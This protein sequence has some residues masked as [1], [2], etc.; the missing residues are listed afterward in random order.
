MDIEPDLTYSLSDAII[1]SIE[2][3]L[4][5][6]I[7]QKFNYS[8]VPVRK[9]NKQLLAIIEIKRIL[10]GNVVAW[11]VLYNNPNGQS[12]V[13]KFKQFQQEE[14]DVVLYLRNC[15]ATILNVNNI[16]VTVLT[17][18]YRNIEIQQAR[19]LSSFELSNASEKLPVVSTSDINLERNK[20]KESIE[21]YPQ[22]PKVNIESDNSDTDVIYIMKGYIWKILLPMFQDVSYENSN[23]SADSIPNPN[24]QGKQGPEEIDRKKKNF[25]SKKDQCDSCNYDFVSLYRSF[26][27]NSSQNHGEVVGSS[28]LEEM[29]LLRYLIYKTRNERESSSLEVQHF[30]ST[31]KD[32]KSLST[33]KTSIEIQKGDK[34]KEMRAKL[35]G[36]LQ[37]FTSIYKPLIFLVTPAIKETYEQAGEEQTHRELAKE[38]ELKVS[39]TSLIQDMIGDTD[40]INLSFP[41]VIED[42]LLTLLLANIPASIFDVQKLQRTEMCTFY[43]KRVIELLFSLNNSYK[44]RECFLFKLTKQY[45]SNRRNKV[46]SSSHFYYKVL[47]F[48]LLDADLSA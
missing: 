24:H 17:N 37:D 44:S 43:A 5:P 1:I 29:F 8:G 3:L 30:N 47:D 11:L 9:R 28:S 23:P 4:T 39:S 7:I 32:V 33:M 21:N 20:G 41:V 19:K 27:E 38:S 25:F 6:E 26:E 18:E 22:N 46:E 12:L 40:Q 35:D 2:E 42:P 48:E 45:K 34:E 14:E 31:D 15:S 13:R 10:H 36:E 16:P